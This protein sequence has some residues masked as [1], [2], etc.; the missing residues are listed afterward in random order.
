MPASNSHRPAAELGT[1]GAMSPTAW[2]LATLRIH[3]RSA[4][5]NFD[6]ANEVLR[7]LGQSVSIFR[8]HIATARDALKGI[9]DEKP[10]GPDNFMLILGASEK[11]DEFNFARIVSEAHLISCF[12]T[13]RGMWDHF[14]QLVNLVV[15]GASIPISNCDISKVL[16]RL[17]ESELREYVLSTL[18]SH[19]Y[20]YVVAF[21]N[22]VKHRRLVEH[23]F[24]VSFEENRAGVRVGAF[25]YEAKSFPAYWG[26]EVL[27][28]VIEV[29]NRVIGAGRLLNEAVLPQ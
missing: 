20:G 8:Y 2:D 14:A 18:S 27:E 28:G 5:S 7:S 24:S 9:V 1:L 10:A 29:K 6:L 23:S 13:A 15:L 22:T 21:V 26:T 3:L 19:W 11:S 4:G 12:H 17:P 16:A 25:S